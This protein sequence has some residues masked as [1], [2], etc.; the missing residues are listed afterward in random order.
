MKWLYLIVTNILKQL[1]ESRGGEMLNPADE[2]KKLFK[3]NLVKILLL[4]ATI[5]GVVGF[6]VAGF[7]MTII[8][9]A[10]QYD[11]KEKYHITGV[12]TSGIALMVIGV[13]VIT[14]AILFVT[15]DI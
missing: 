1:M 4:F 13:L 6:F 2:I 7:V 5:T 10:I 12:I 15:K 14:S 3:Q 9:L 8:N 11:L